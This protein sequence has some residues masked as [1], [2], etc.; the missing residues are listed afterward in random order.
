MIVDFER[1]IVALLLLLFGFISTGV[2]A[3][4]HRASMADDHSKPQINVLTDCG[5]R[6][7]GQTDDS[8]AIQH[9]ID[10]HPS[11]TILFPKSNSSGNCDYNLSQTISF[12]SYS[13]ALQGEGGTANNN[14]TLCWISDV[15]GISIAGGQGQAIRDI[16][17]RGNSPFNAV[18]SV[19][20]RQGSAD[21]IRVNG[22]QVSL[23]DIYVSGFSR[24]GVNVDSRLGGVPDEWIFEN[25]RAE[26]NR[27]DGF[28]FSGQDANAGLC[29]LC[30]SRLNQG[31]GFYDAAVIPSTFVAPLTD[32]NH[33]DPTSPLMTVEIKQIVVNH[34]IATV[35]TAREHNTIPGDWGVIS[36][37]PEFANKWPVINVPTSSTL[38]FRTAKGDGSYCHSGSA[39]YGYQAGA[40]VWASGR[41][42]DD[43]EMAPGSYN[44][45]SPSAHWTQKDYGALVCVAGAGSGRKELCATVKLITGNIA[46]LTDAAAS[47][48]HKGTARIVTNGGPFNA[49]NSTFVESYTEGNQEGYSQLSNS[50]TLGTNWG[51][52]ANWELENLVINNGY[53]S[54]LK[55]VRRNLLGGYAN[56]IFQA[57]RAFGYGSIAREPSY[58]GFWNVQETDNQGSVLA[59]L[60]FRRSNVTGAVASGWNC[61]TQDTRSEG[62]ALAASSVCLPDTHTRVAVNGSPS[63]TQLPMFPAGGFWVKGGGVEDAATSTTGLRQVRYDQLTTPK[64][65]NTGDIF[66]GSAPAA[67]G[68]V[69]WVCTTPNT[70]LPFGKIATANDTSLEEKVAVPVSSKQ[71]CSLGQWASDSAYYYICIAMN[72]WRRAALTAW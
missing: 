44:L 50:L 56:S 9:C 63:P 34:K 69:G 67:G 65:C 18:K 14:T 16:N 62:A 10:S 6:G 20:Y 42:V 55:F 37:C 52:V 72:T 24:H 13:T 38:Q 54:P 11:R 64:S 68:Y 19:T 29:L 33:N 4:E 46:V 3:Q 36:G 35:T 27:G 31:W 8:A 26:G 5:A 17:L 61:F 32:A 48:V 21:G 15:T 49:S 41:N 22:C 1:R 70:P 23:R 2:L 47:D 40:R 39:R 58:E 59:A 57:G 60:S 25:V 28:H 71:S 12:S 51:T 45:T 7:D 66:Y 30:I 43:A 53:A